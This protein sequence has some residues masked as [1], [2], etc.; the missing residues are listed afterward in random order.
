MVRSSDPECEFYIDHGV[1]IK[2]GNKVW[3]AVRPEKIRVSVEAPQASAA[4]QISGT[5]HDVGYLG[6]IS[7]YRVQVAEGHIVEVTHPNQSRPRG[8]KRPVDWDD[9][10]YLSWEPSSAVVLT[11]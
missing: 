10:V 6:N 3:V 7:T 11:E 1:S 8:D 9:E 5:V 4:N 2:E